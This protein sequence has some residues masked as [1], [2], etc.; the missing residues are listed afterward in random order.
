MKQVVSLAGMEADPFAD[1]VNLATTEG[2][3]VDLEEFQGG[4]GVIFR[5]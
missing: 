1:G 3:L 2:R 5:E 4:Y